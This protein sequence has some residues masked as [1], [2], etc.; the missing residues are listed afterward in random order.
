MMGKAKIYV[1]FAFA[2][3]GFGFVE[4]AYGKRDL[5]RLREVIKDEFRYWPTG[6][7]FSIFE[8]DGPRS[9]AKFVEEHVN[10]RV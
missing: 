8:F 3:D 5:K 4:C 6:T 7:V 10:T 9:D 2:S 1:V